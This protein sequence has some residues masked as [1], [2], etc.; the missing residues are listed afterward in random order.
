MR[1]WTR[2]KPDSELKAQGGDEIMHATSQVS[3]QS[4]LDLLCI[5]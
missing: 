2:E 3:H 5:M 4:E 1:R